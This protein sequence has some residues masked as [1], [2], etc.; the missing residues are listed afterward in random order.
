RAAAHAARDADLV[1]AHWLPA[2]AVAATLGKP[3]VVQVWGTDVELARRVPW[4]ARRLLRRARLVIAASK[5]L[6]GEARALGAREVCVVPSGVPIPEDVGPP[7]EP[8]HV[9]YVG[10]LSAEKGILEFLEAT[11]GLRRVIVGA[12]PL[13][14]QVPE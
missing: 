13:R 3:F 8:P 5:F 4:L 6:A 1:H 7:E 12:G 14:D 10:R 2:G 9:L 11:E